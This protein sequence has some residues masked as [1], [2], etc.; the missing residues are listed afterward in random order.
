MSY[1]LTAHDHDLSTTTTAIVMTMLVLGS[2]ATGS[3][4]VGFRQTDKLVKRTE[5]H[6]EAFAADPGSLVHQIP[7]IT[8]PTYLTDRSFFTAR[9][10]VVLLVFA[11]ICLLT[12]LIGVHGWWDQP[13]DDQSNS[14]TTRLTGLDEEDEVEAFLGA[15]V[16]VVG[17]LAIF[18]KRLMDQYYLPEDVENEFSGKELE[19]LLTCL[20]K[21]K[22]DD[23]AIKMTSQ[24]DED[25]VDAIPDEIDI[26][27]ADSDDDIEET[28]A[29]LLRVHRTEESVQ[30]HFVQ[31]D[32]VKKM[33]VKERNDL[34][35]TTLQQA[36]KLKPTFSFSKFPE[37]LG[38][39]LEKNKSVAKINRLGSV[40]VDE[41]VRASFRETVLLSRAT[42]DGG[43]QMGSRI[44]RRAGQGQHVQFNTL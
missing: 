12:A 13:N 23:G 21:I 32:S 36:E 39:H 44:R 19:E 11:F 33:D 24:S 30:R 18:A 20:N 29:G 31:D 8:S 28:G 22:I 43:I 5:H 4:M 26:Y 16:A 17:G 34:A 14:T 27:A 37:S 1:Y 7:A 15:V 25:D 6:I 35:S 10:Q 2:L 42:S 9:S 41:F 38:R 40:R 3:L